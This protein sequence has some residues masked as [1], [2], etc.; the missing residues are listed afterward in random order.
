MSKIN[1]FN[2]STQFKDYSTSQFISNY[3]S[4][5]I[6]TRDKLKTSGNHNKSISLVLDKS[7]SSENKKSTKGVVE[8]LSTSKQNESISSSNYIRRAIPQS[9]KTITTK[10]KTNNIRNIGLN[11]NS[12]NRNTSTTFAAKRQKTKSFDKKIN[13]SFVGININTKLTISNNFSVIN[14]GM[15]NSKSPK[16]TVNNVHY[17]PK[18]MSLLGQMDMLKMKAKRTGQ[19]FN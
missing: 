12:L 10:K 14:T 1:S 9:S 16:Y 18:Q 5:S 7:I 8:S 3:H 19:K 2:T 4:N 17:K 13:K 15:G 6:G 11:R